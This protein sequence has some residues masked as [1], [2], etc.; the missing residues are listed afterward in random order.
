[1][2]RNER[3]PCNENL[4]AKYLC[5]RVFHAVAMHALVMAG[6]SVYPG[7]MGRYLSYVA[8]E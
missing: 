3:L 4:P 2:M 8:I 5:L 6:E 1:M 7:R